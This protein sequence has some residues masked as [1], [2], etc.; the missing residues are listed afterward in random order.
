MLNVERVYTETM[1]T[2]KKQQHL[3]ISIMSCSWCKIIFENSCENL[4]GM[5]SISESFL[6]SFISGIF[7]VVLVSD[8]VDMVRQAPVIAM[9]TAQLVDT[10][11]V[12]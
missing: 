5:A 10:K 12:S 2:H 6:G 3:N 1:H 8:V 4:Y 11:N 7:S 9:K